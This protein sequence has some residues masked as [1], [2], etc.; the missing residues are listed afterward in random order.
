M[1]F[2][3]SVKEIMREAD[4]ILHVLDARMPELSRNKDVERLADDYRKPLVVVFN[5]IDLVPRKR[6]SELREENKDAYFVSG[7][8]K[9]GMKKLKTGLILIGK[10]LGR[11]NPKIGIVGYPNVG[12]SSII[13]CL[14]YG[15]RAAVAPVAGTTK[16]P[17]F[18]KA[19]G[20]KVIDSPGI[21]P[22][23]DD[24]IKLGILSAKNPEKLRNPE[25]VAQ[26]IINLVLR[27]DKRILENYYQIEVR[28]EDSYK[29][30]L[31]IGRHKGMLKKKGVVDETKTSISLVRDW[32][33]GKI[34]V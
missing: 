14:A 28:D 10:S 9:I 15:A 27:T 26:E 25:R 21:I 33:R 24:E 1:G 18:V 29:I 3:F 22:I 20:L 16:G 13:N 34:R 31:D 7:A 2:W 32:Q 8:E 4:V 17:Q 19:G 23:E 30:L 11:F 6:L 12:K 5:K